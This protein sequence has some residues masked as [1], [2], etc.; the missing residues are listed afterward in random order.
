MIAEA[1]FDRDFQPLA[2]NRTS[3]IVD[4][5]DGRIPTLTPTATEQM[6]MCSGF[7]QCGPQMMGPREASMKGIK[8]DRASD[9]SL[10]ERC[11]AISNGPPFLSAAYN[12]NVHILHRKDVVVIQ[13][14]MIHTARSVW[15]DGRPRPDPS[16]TLW[17][18]YSLG[19]WEGDT[20][21]IETT[22]FRPDFSWLGVLH[23][24]NFTLVERLTR[25]DAG[26]VMYEYTMNDP[27]TWPRPWTV[28]HP[29]RK[30]RGMMYEYACH[31]G[32]YGL[33]FQL[34]ANRGREK[35]EAAK[36]GK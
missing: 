1:P 24:E 12:N 13:T 19:H 5:P 14:E 26:T 10:S 20:L 25:I 31:E 30:L 33:K 4:P 17:T 35:Q 36:Q 7:W 16:V 21:V 3:L 15:V 22:N 27:E 18:G 11:L 6:A 8:V 32:N 23:P 29:M 28:Q 34:M 2:Q 9:R